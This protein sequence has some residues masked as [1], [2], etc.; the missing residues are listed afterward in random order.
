MI[1][2]TT[3]IVPR[4][5]PVYH[6]WVMRDIAIEGLC[7]AISRAWVIE[8]RRTAKSFTSSWGGGALYIDSTY[9]YVV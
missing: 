2:V 3:S 4:A 7:R 6:T 5:I 1:P 8:V 9:L